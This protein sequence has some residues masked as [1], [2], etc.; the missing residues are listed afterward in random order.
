M[1]PST[2]ETTTWIRR[3][4]PV[5]VA[6]VAAAAFVAIVPSRPSGNATATFAPRGEPTGTSTASAPATCLRTEVV[7]ANACPP[8][9]TDGDNGGTT[10]EQGVTGDSIT[11]VVYSGANNTQ[12][13]AVTAG[14]TPT[15]AQYEDIVESFERWYN[16]AF[17]TY[18]RHVDLRYY[19]GEG[20]STASGAQAIAQDLAEDVGAFAV[21]GQNLGQ[22]LQEELARRQV[23]SAGLINQYAAE[24][25]ED[26]APFIYGLFPDVDLVLEHVAEYYCKRL[27]GRPAIH[28]GEELQETERRLGI[29]HTASL[30]DAGP[31]LASLV[32]DCGGTVA[33]VVEYSPDVEVATQQWTNTMLQLEESGATTVVCVCDPVAPVF[34]TNAAA[35]QD[36][37]PEYL[38]TGYGGLESYQAGQLYQREQ[39]SHYFGPAVIPRRV[40]GDPVDANGYRAYSWEHPSPDAEVA[41]FLSQ[42]YNLL[43]LTMNGIE[44]A[45]PALDP[46]T[47]RDG[48]FVDRIP[49]ADPTSPAISFGPGGPSPYTAIDDFAELWWDPDQIGPNGKPGRPFY[50]DGGQRHTLGEWPAQDPNVFVDD[51]SPQGGG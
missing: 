30:H 46:G 51:G 3:Y 11:V 15:D 13:Q 40:N 23:I 34:A 17:Q 48:L 2:S 39:W 12:V 41:E 44:R 45:G 49:P 4:A 22:V 14:T 26:N 25:Y 28:A 10:W 9:W 6:L 42:I 29:V 7:D 1:T 27:D 24:V 5:T 33:R 43:N 18:G 37:E 36:Y 50:V 38:S 21:V 19:V 47:F 32:E 16:A 8:T 20:G 35:A 31:R